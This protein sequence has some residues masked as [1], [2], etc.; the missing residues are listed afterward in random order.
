MAPD[1]E[2]TSN[3]S[4]ETSTF[5]SAA[6]PA[7][8]EEKKPAAETSIKERVAREP[9]PE[10]QKPQVVQWGADIRD[11]SVQ[12]DSN[13]KIVKGVVSGIQHIRTQK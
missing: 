2:T 3:T 12:Y 10:K 7:S 5:Q 4:D 8:S 13:R 11:I 9:E 6:G 1:L